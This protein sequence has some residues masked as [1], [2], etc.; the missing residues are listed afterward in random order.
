MDRKDS[1]WSQDAQDP[2]KFMHRVSS[3][4]SLKG[5]GVGASPA[6]SIP[7][8][9][10]SLRLPPENEHDRSPSPS[11]APTRE[12]FERPLP[13]QA[14]QTGRDGVWWKNFNLINSL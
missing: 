3:R 12:D 13:P 2:N 4:A 1:E 7:L 8:A 6:P 11:P 14:S 9:P 10:E 5:K